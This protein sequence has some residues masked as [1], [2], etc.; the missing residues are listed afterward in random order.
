MGCAVRV[1]AIHKGGFRPGVD[2]MIVSIIGSRHRRSAAEVVPGPGVD[3]VPMIAVVAL[4]G[5]ARLLLVGG[6]NLLTFGLIEI[7]RHYY[8]P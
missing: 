6:G 7:G 5:R 2:D 4:A 8:G 1:M 3:F